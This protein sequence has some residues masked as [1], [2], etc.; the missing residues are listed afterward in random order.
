MT[1]AARG[2]IGV[3][4]KRY[5]R[6]VRVVVKANRTVQLS[7]VIEFN[8]R[9]TAAEAYN[10]AGELKDINL[11]FNNQI[12]N[13]SFELMQNTPN[14]FV[15]ETSIGFTLPEAS[16]ATLT[17]SDV[18]GKVIRII[19]GEFA[20]GFNQVTINQSELNGTGVLYYQLD[21][22]TDSAVRKMILLNT[23]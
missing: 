9:Y 7:D 12:A 13:N 2:G 19:E 23:K 21:T 20:K 22:P 3:I 16:S 5:Y 14:P 6:V 8:S 15:D 18:S 1:D 17:I 4:L 10:E 11:E